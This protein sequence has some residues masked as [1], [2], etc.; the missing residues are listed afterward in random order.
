ML[1][2][3]YPTGNLVHARDQFQT[4]GIRR[5]SPKKE[6]CCHLHQLMA[7]LT[8]MI[9]LGAGLACSRTSGA[10]EATD[11]AEVPYTLV[12]HREAGDCQKVR[13]I[14]EVQGELRWK[15]E[16]NDQPATAPLT[17]RGELNFVERLLELDE[18]TESASS[19]RHYQQAEAT[20][21]VGSQVTTR[22]LPDHQRLLLNQLQDGRVLITS[23]AQPLTRDEL[24]LVDIHGNTLGLPF[25]LPAGA[26]SL[27]DRWE[28]PEHALRVL[29]GL[30]AI[31]ENSVTASV[32]SVTNDIA[33]IELQGD[34][35][36]D[37][38]G[39]RTRISL[40]AKCNFDMNH[41]QVTWF[42]AVVREERE[43]SDTQPGFQVTARLRVAIQPTN[44]PETL[45][46]ETVAIFPA[47]TRPPVPLLRHV[48]SQGGF[49]MMVDSGWRTIVERAD[50]TILRLFERGDLVAQLLISPLPDGPA[51]KQLNL[52]SFEEEVRG[53]VAPHSGQIV[54]SAEGLNEDGIRVLRVV[55]A[56]VVSEV[57]MQWVYYHISDPSGRRAALAFTVQTDLIEPFAERD[58]AMLETFQFLERD[59]SDSQQDAPAKEGKDVA[60]S[61]V[62]DK[63]TNSAPL[64]PMP[65]AQQ[66]KTS[67]TR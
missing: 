27:E 28:V 18:T 1:F 12:H 43:I 13:A 33:L 37:A 66:E 31:T 58:R 63:L 7:A 42:T 23:P 53:G 52:K 5:W 40:Q 51:D 32:K 38:G 60:A 65:T 6:A 26:V 29:F 14:L 30:D 45:D 3:A 44:V 48:S 57:S 35:D 55:A 9:A 61:A 15:P 59:D 22:Q 49:E 11:D 17:A 20:L 2:F 41:R 24:D 39:S 8:L 21:Q 64:S 34:F 16:K 62:D 67:V 10:K 36:G 50:V 46:D 25:L 54:E 56:G 19:A 4:A 47:A